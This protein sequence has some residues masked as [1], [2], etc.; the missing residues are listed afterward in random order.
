MPADTFK[1]V[2]GQS[3][4]TP[5]QLESLQLGDSPAAWSDAG[6]LVSS[7]GTV[8]LGGT[9]IVCTGFGQPFQGWRI[10]GLGAL[11]PEPLITQIDGLQ[12]LP[13]V[14][15]F[16]A[17]KSANGLSFASETQ[18]HPNGV[19]RIDH[20]VVSTGN[21]D[22]TINAFTAAGFERRG[23]RST[24]QFGAQML[25][26]FFWAGDVIVELVGPSLV[27]DANDSLA[28]IFGLAM[29]AE[30]LQHTAKVLGELLGNP[31]AAV[32]PGRQIAGL[33]TQSIGIALPIAIM[34]PHQ[35]G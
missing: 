5:R 19:T 30:D 13:S 7:E 1:A 17:E 8:R 14:Q 9:T 22:R 21:C 28:S 6:F 18:P 2:Q 31:K 16:E 26:T 15:G 20:I 24:T 23:S 12:L 4:S 29:V 27:Q 3:D 11:S 25:Q 34:S 32:Q 10:Q 35:A 33:R